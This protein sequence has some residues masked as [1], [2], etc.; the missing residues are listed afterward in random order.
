MKLHDLRPAEGATQK[1]K[2]VGRGTGSGKGKTS[3]RGQ[4]GQNSRSGGSVRINF[5]GGQ[6]PLTK[7]LPKLRGF[8]NRFKVYYVPVNLDQIERLFD[9]Q[10][11]VSQATLASAG[12]LGNVA[13]PVVVLAR[14]EV[15]KPLTLKVQRISVTARQKI[16]AAG[17]S[18][19]VLEYAANKRMPRS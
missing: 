4:K 13:D 8:N 15:T 2:R 16:E 10:A 19:E 1:R 9:A 3:G 14:G 18:V 6:L 17:G 5:E 11:E 7:R 12:L